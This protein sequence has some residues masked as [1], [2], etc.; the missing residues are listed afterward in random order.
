MNLKTLTISVIILTLLSAGVAFLN[1]PSAPA[2][3]DPRVGQ[4]LLDAT[5]AAAANDL[6]LTHAGTTVELTRDDQGEWTVA[7]YHDLPADVAK[8]SRFVRELTE[9][10]VDR[11]VTRDPERAARLDFG[12]SEIAIT[13][14]DEQ[15]WTA[16]LGKDAERGG[17]YV[18]F[19]SAP[20]A[21][22]YLARLS[23]YLDG[24]PKNWANSK[25]IGLTAED[26]A[27][28]SFAVAE[29][30]AL[31]ASRSEPGGSWSST[32]LPEGQ[33]LKDSRL[34]SMLSS[35][36]NLRFTDTA[37]R[38]APDAVDAAAS[39]E[40]RTVTLTTFDGQTV[41]IALARRAARTVEKDPAEIA[42]P[43][44]AADDE[45]PTIPEDTTETIPA[46]PVFASVTGDADLAPLTDAPER[47]AFKVSDYSFTG[48]PTAITELYEPIPAPPGETDGAAGPTP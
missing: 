10:T 7:S 35:L 23:S 18:R 32:D 17:R 46:G 9:A 15:S 11:I 41:S 20:D 2:N 22:A 45:G 4:P 6:T 12:S 8:L 24:T 47:L 31:T 21:P 5:I 44:E 36:A 48:L 38:D 42:P 3:V 27:S 26:V 40:S 13:T 14:A 43:T 1:R 16:H 29:T 25:M 30:D 33:R 19:D 34:T 37:P 39:A 28:I